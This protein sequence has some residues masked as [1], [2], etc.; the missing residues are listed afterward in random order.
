MKDD[1]TETRNPPWTMRTIRE[2]M[3]TMKMLMEYEGCNLDTEI[4]WYQLQDGSLTSVEHECCH[5]FN[6][7]ES[8]VELTLKDPYRDA[9][10]HLPE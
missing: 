4:V 7:E 2:V 10:G 9:D 3:D 8:R 1:Y 5:V 6:D